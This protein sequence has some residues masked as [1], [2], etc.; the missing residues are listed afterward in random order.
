MANLITRAR[1]IYNLANRATTS[2]ENTTLDALIAAVS[3]G[4]ENYCWRTFAITSYD[5]LYP[6]NDRGELLLVAGCK[7]A[8]VGHRRHRG[9]D[10]RIWSVIRP[11]GPHVVMPSAVR[12]R[13][14]SPR[15]RCKQG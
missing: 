1:A 12:N 11:Y 15:L 4:I 2:D 14:I 10:R 6:G 8:S 9:A 7:E 13:G 5:E 3:K